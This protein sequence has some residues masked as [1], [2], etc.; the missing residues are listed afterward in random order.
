MN[1]CHTVRKTRPSH[2]KLNA[3]NIINPPPLSP[4]QNPQSDPQKVRNAACISSHVMSCDWWIRGHYGATGMACVVPHALSQSQER[5]RDCGS[6]RA[7]NLASFDGLYQISWIWGW[8]TI[9]LPTLKPPSSPCLSAR[10]ECS[11]QRLHHTWRL[12]ATFMFR[13][14]GLRRGLRVSG[15]MCYTAKGAMVNL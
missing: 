8:F 7:L 3:F 4:T 14:S 13:W 15:C 1:P 5:P 6:S 11:V 9:A 12:P 2:F 10:E